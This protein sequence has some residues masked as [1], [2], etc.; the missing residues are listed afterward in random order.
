M[1]SLS[2]NE[3]DLISL[4]EEEE[5]RAMRSTEIPISDAPKKVTDQIRRQIKNRRARE[6]RMSRDQ[7]PQLPY[8]P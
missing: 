8:R 2:D 4:Q 5:Q 1:G 6:L 3:R 7:P